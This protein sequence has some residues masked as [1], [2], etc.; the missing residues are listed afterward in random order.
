VRF[1]VSHPSVMRLRKGGGTLRSR[2]SEVPQIRATRQVG[3][4]EGAGTF[5][6]LNSA[7]IKQ[8]F[9]PGLY[10]PTLQV[11]KSAGRQ[12]RGSRDLQVPE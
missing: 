2:L 8:A 4:T 3:I 10:F 7:H 6:S 1:K 11:S 12:H 9:R 5:R